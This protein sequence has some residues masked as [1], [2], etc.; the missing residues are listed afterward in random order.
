VLQF[1]DF[2]VVAVWQSLAMTQVKIEGKNQFVPRPTRISRHF[3]EL[4]LFELPRLLASVAKLVPAYCAW[5]GNARLSDIAIASPYVFS[6][7]LG[8]LA[9]NWSTAVM[10]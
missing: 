10:T 7:K 9:R 2:S 4:G 1:D 5:H 8:L 6:A 3:P